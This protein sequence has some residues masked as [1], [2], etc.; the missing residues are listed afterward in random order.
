MRL[1]RS[2][3][4]PICLTASLAVAQDAQK[5]SPA[6]LEVLK[7][8]ETLRE[9]ALKRDMATWSA[10][11]A[12]DCIFST[13]DGTLQ[14]KAQFVEHVGKMPPAYDRSE[15]PRDYIIH[16]Y[17]DAAVVNF[18]LTG[19][20]QFTDADIHS[21][22]RQTETYVKRN[23]AWQLVA[24]QWGLLPVN[25]RKPAADVDTSK[26]KD[27]AGR[28]E[29]RPG[30]EVDVI[31]VQDGRVWSNMGGDEQEA[32]PLGSGTFFFKND[33]G[34]TTFIRDGTGKV[35]GYIYHRVDGQEIHVRKIK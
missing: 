33:L 13:D 19:H 31:L 3:L 2:F 14:T 34:T 8:R 11:V 9:S 30:D 15:N 32:L 5:F 7:V 4:L 17:G 21:E 24:R 16:V 12:D 10:Y 23:G 22:E 20:E 18:R 25:F 1:L 26:F 28:Y 6:Q 29:W 27:Y 35:S